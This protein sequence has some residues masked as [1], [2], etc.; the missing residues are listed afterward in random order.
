MPG[1][2][3]IMYSM[4]RAYDQEDKLLGDSNAKLEGGIKTDV[5]IPFD[6][7]T[8]IDVYSN[9]KDRALDFAAAYLMH[10]RR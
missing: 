5:L 4:M 9:G 8:A 10:H 6:T 1:N 3:D 7:N 2:F